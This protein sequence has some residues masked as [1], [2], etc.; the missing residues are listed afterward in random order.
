SSGSS[1][2]RLLGALDERLHGR[3]ET[4]A[5]DVDEAHLAVRVDDV[6]THARDAPGDGGVVGET[7]PREDLPPR[8]RVRLDERVERGPVLVERDADDLDLVL[9][10]RDDR[11]RVRDLLLVRLVGRGPEVDDDDLPEVGVEL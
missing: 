6:A 9:V 8:D 11:E 3:G 1:L 10:A 7:L 5:A 4:L 2:L